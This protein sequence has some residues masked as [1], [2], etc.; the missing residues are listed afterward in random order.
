MAVRVSAEQVIVKDNTDK[1]DGFGTRITQV[2]L[3]AGAVEARIDGARHTLTATGYTFTDSSGNEI[4]SLTKGLANEQNFNAMDN[5]E[6]DFPLRF[7][8]H[9]GESV[10][11]I[12]EVILKWKNYPYRAFSTGAAS[13]GGSTS[14]S[15]GYYASTTGDRNDANYWRTT[16]GPKTSSDGSHTHEYRAWGH[17]HGFTV[18]SH[19]HSTPNHT[20]GIVYGIYEAS[21]GAHASSVYVDG[22]K[23]A[24]ITY[25]SST[26]NLSSWITTSGWH[27]IEIRSTSRKRIEATLFMKTYIR[28]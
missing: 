12:E 27:T 13:G 7:A 1:V 24:D 21:Q 17:T 5:V 6:N 2:E 4:F 3:R 9:I 18:G 16:L 11:S 28:R 14:G 19:T 25:S 10:N 23:R 26:L 15:G 20:H 8:F 22:T